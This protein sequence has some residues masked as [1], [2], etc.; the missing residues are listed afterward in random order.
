ME[1]I[2]NEDVLRTVAFFRYINPTAWIRMA[3][4]R[5]QFLDG[6]AELELVTDELTGEKKL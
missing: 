1:P 5:G 3:A 6:G 2:S 4:G